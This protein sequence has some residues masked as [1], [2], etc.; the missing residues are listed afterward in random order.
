L[1]RNL[2]AGIGN[3]LLMLRKE[4]RLSHTALER[5]TGLLRFH[6]SRLENGHDIPK[7]ETLQKL[8]AAFEI[9]LHQLFYEGEGNPR[10]RLLHR[11]PVDETPYER[12]LHRFIREMNESDRRIILYLVRKL[13]KNKRGRSKRR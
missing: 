1:N 2:A 3:W 7:I 5:R 13:A 4:R 12:Q 10:T 8:A 9:P 6:I 11:P